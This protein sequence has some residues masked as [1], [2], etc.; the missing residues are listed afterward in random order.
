MLSLTI[1]E[2]NIPIIS[3]VGHEV[4]FTIA[5]FWF[6]F[7]IDLLALVFT[8]AL[9]VFVFYS[10]PLQA[11]HKRNHLIVKW[12]LLTFL[13]SYWFEKATKL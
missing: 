6:A 8:I 11:L 13:K 4:D 1:F 2:S 9:F 7:I 5:L 10:Q 3:A 12:I